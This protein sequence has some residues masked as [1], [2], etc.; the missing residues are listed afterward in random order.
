MTKRQAGTEAIGWVEH[1]ERLRD[2]YVAAHRER[3]ERGEV[4]INGDIDSASVETATMRIL[5]L[6]MSGAFNRILVFINSPGGAVDEGFSIID[7]MMLLPIPVWTINIGIAESMG[8]SI[9]LAGERRFA[10]PHSNF[11]A[12]SMSYHRGSDKL[13]EQ[14]SYLD[15]VR[16]KQSQHAEFYSNRTKKT[17]KWWLSRFKEADYYFDAEQSVSLGVATDYVDSADTFA[18]IFEEVKKGGKG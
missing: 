10:L 15:Y 11:M 12:H 5:T 6:G 18:E 14:E 9:F 16:L 7:T 3:L 1:S 13:D 8:L 4:W 17:T 2:Y